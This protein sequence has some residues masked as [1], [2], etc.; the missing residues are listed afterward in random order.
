M[1]AMARAVTANLRRFVV[2]DLLESLKTDSKAT[3]ICYCYCFSRHNFHEF[4]EF[5]FI[6]VDGCR[7]THFVLLLFC[8][9][10]F[11]FFSGLE[12]NLKKKNF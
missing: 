2:S 10:L 9:A 5:N 7:G 6:E 3:A 1:P 8:F 11:V 4:H 12:D